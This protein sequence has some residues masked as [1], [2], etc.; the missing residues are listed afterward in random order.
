MTSKAPKKYIKI[1]VEDSG[2]VAMSVN[3]DSKYN[4]IE[5][6]GLIEIA[7]LNLQKK[8]SLCWGND[9]QKDREIH[10][11]DSNK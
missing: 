1:W 2:E 8:I 10:K 11:N 6:M 3:I 4:I 5:S 9:A 7:K